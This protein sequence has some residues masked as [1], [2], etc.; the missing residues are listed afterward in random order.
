MA[1]MK[2]TPRQKMIG[3]MYL[4]LTAMLAL[5]VS[6]QVLNA[7][8]VVNTGLT[9]T[10][11]NYD[12]KNEATYSAFAKAYKQN[13]A[14][15]KEFYDRANEAKKLSDQLCYYIRVLKDTLI[16]RT[17]DKP[18]KIADSIST[19]MLSMAEVDAK[20]NFDIPTRI[21]INDAAAEDG[22]KGK[23]HALALKMAD[24]RK[25]MLGLL[26]NPK[27]SNDVKVGLLTSKVFNKES[28]EYEN[29]EIYNFYDSPLAA[30]VVT[31][32]RLQN[33]VKNAEA[34]IVQ[35]L[36][37]SI[38]VASFKF[39]QLSA[40][41]IPASN[42]VLIGKS[43][44]AQ[45]FLSAFDSKQNPVVEID[46][47]NNQKLETP[48]N[49]PVEGGIGQYEEKPGREGPITFGGKIGV[50]DPQT[51][52]LKY[53]PFHS[54]YL[55]AKPAITVSPTE[56]NVFYIGVDN[57]VEISAAGFSDNDITPSFSGPGHLS[58]KAGKYVI[59]L[60]PS[61]ARQ[62]MECTISVQGKLP[63]GSKMDLGKDKFRIKRIPNP[64]CYVANKSGDISIPKAQLEAATMVQARM[65]NFDF[66]LKYGV[67]SFELVASVNG[68]TLTKSSSSASLTDEM[69]KLIHQCGR[70]SHII[71]QNVHV[72][73]PDTRTIP[74]VNIAIN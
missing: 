21:M 73:G 9:K 39:D 24:V 16:S 27:D 68:L 41:I 6:R 10:N 7:F 61:T 69:K 31:L 19:G 22:S 30:S 72:K 53:Y 57:P 8:V 70:G 34:S 62:G 36:Y 13:P 56:M 52:I 20:E 18:W 44:K 54:A 33:D 5:N 38:D 17:D 28:R 2:E 67:T 42:Y 37:K 58:G 3:M 11:K 74:G 46:S 45:I 63:D 26:V 48:V 15:V 1:G 43:Y 51:G 60:E 71:I 32:T 12:D 23:A 40:E 65:D 66:D 50:R 49:P 59:T 25:K 64:T 14:K 47:M 55:A 4:V 29:W 35:D